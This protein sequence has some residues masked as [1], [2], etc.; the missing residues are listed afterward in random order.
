VTK[1]AAPPKS[2]VPAKPRW[3]QTR[4]LAFIDLRLQY[5]G[6]LNRK[7]IRDFF[8][9]STPQATAD[10]ELYSETAQGN[11]RYDYKEKAYVA[12]P[13]FAPQY[14]RSHATRYLG[15][16]YR[17]ATGVIDA[18]ESFV[19]IRPPVGVVATPARAI[20]STVVAQLVR[21]IDQGLSF[22]VMYHSM[23]EATPAPRVISPHALGFDGLRWHVRAWCHTRQLFSDFAIGRLELE[24]FTTADPV[25]PAQ[26]EGWHTWVQLEL[27]PHEKLTP[28]QREAV[29]H[30][31][32]MRD[33]VCQV[34]CRKAMV[35]YTLRHLNLEQPEDPH[36]AA[37]QHVVLANRA[38]AERWMDE[39]RHGPRARRAKRESV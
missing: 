11:L 20:D 15:D 1:S 6:K 9:I 16:L 18:D 32:D 17:L 31:Y 35:F 8:H 25:D 36:Q 33:G 30:D 24:G 4:R 39:D 10:L 34:D 27:K 12:E 37:T 26:D 22:K 38:D 2:A 28:S 23:S 14:G 21:A 29:M 5:D 3:G 7:D 13:G 19:G